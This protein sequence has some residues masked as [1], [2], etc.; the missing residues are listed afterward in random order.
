[1]HPFV[2]EDL[3]SINKC[4]YFDYQRDRVFARSSDVV[5]KARRSKD[6]RQHVLPKENKVIEIQLA[7]SDLTGIGHSGRC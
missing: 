5:R 4:A 6:I 1:A 2:L 3:A 7:K